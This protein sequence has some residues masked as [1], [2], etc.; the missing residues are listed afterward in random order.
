M[1]F[2][3]KAKKYFHDELKL[4]NRDIS[5]RMNGYSEVLISRYLNQDT[6][7]PTFINKIQEF[8]PEADIN[9][10]TRKDNDL[11]AEPTTLYMSEAVKK[12]DKIINELQ[13]LRVT[14]SQ[15]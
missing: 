1:G 11:V 3:E 10:L 8:F 12:I 13:E 6:L 5:K 7:S 4:T 14:L 9:Y 2:S 15:N